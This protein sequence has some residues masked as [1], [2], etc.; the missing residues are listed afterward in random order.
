[1]ETDPFSVTVCSESQ[2]CLVKVVVI[3]VVVMIKLIVA[4]VVALVIL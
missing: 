3:V 2:H 4:V 1:M